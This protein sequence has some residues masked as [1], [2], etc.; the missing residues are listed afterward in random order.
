MRVGF[1]LRLLLTH[2]IIFCWALPI[3]I[4]AGKLNLPGTLNLTPC[5]QIT[6][7]RMLENLVSR[8]LA[9]GP[10]EQKALGI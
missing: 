1:V 9:T 4:E 10:S 8:L 6:E 7:Y 2:E 5:L 3:A